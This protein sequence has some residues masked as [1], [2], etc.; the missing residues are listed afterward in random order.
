MGFIVKLEVVVCKIK[1]IILVILMI[2]VQGKP[3]SIIKILHAFMPSECG[4]LLYNVLT[5]IETIRAL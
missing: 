4:M 2:S 1:S 5:S 3:F